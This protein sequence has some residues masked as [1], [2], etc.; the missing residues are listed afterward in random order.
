M[1][2]PTASRP[3]V[4]P[5]VPIVILGTDAVLAALPATPVQLAHACLR[6]GFANVIPAS[7]GDEIIATA[8]LRRLDRFGDGPAIQCSCP[9]VAHRLLAVGTDLR[10]LLLP[11]VPPPVAIARYVRALSPTTPTRITFIGACPGAVDES[12]DIR[13]TPEALI[14]MLA[15]RQIELQSQPRVFESIIPP[16]RRR[17]SSMPGGVPSPEA[18]W[19]EHGDRALVEVSDEDFVAEISQLVLS[20]E[21]VLIDPSVALGC[22]CSGAVGDEPS[23]QGRHRVMSL[24]PPRA[25]LPV[26]P[27]DKARIDV[28][29]P[30][31]AMSRTPVDIVALPTNS[32]TKP[33][34]VEPAQLPTEPLPRPSMPF[35]QRISPISGLSEVS[36]ILSSRPIATSPPKPIT[37]PTPVA[38]GAEGRSLPRAYVARR[39]SSPRGIRAPQV[40][41]ASAESPTGSWRASRLREH[42]LSTPPSIPVNASI[43]AAVGATLQAP[44]SPTPARPQAFTPVYEPP[45]VPLPRAATIERPPAIERQWMVRILA[46][47]LIIAAAVALGVVIGRSFNKPAVAKPTADSSLGIPY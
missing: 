28:E 30:L 47:A 6:A 43:G 37:G 41:D 1:P 25:A 35:G 44:K 34:P 24:E 21:K 32:L 26:V 9:F 3:P 2:T 40:A 16:D 15:E 12:I 45:E 23:I 20:G 46:G 22:A 8:V 11:L 13:M 29:L 39:R 4:Q 5:V 10:S 14:S 27:E 18:L 33:I 42:P 38:R 19:A 31:P 7:W 36:E 17:H